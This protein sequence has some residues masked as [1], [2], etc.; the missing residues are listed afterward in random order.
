MA[1][2]QET[3]NSQNGIDVFACDPKGLRLDSLGMMLVI[4]W[5]G[6]LLWTPCMVPPSFV[7]SSDDF[8]IHLYR[9]TFLAAFF[10]VYLVASLRPRFAFTV[11][12]H[13][14]VVVAATIV[15]PLVPAVC[16]Y[17]PLS[18][19]CNAIS[20]LPFV[21]WA[22]EGVSAS[23]FMLVWCYGMQTKDGRTNGVTNVVASCFFAGTIYLLLA[24]LQREAAVAL[25]MVLPVIA[26]LVWFYLR[27]EAINADSDVES[28]TSGLST[29]MGNGSS[30][31]VFSYGLAMGAIGGIATQFDN[32]TYFFLT[33]GVSSIASGVVFVWLS[34][35][36]ITLGRR[37]LM[38]C[39]PLISLSFFLLS[40]FVEAIEVAVVFLIVFLV[41]TFNSFN[42]AYIGEESVDSSFG[43]EYNLFL[44]EKR[45]WDALGSLVG[46][47]G[48]T[49]VVYFWHTDIAG[50]LYFALSLAVT[51]AMALAFIKTYETG[52]FVEAADAVE[53]A[54]REESNS[55]NW[56]DA[57]AIISSKYG[58]SPRESEIFVYLSKGR[59]RGFIAQ[60]MFLS[61]NTV[62]S[63]TYNIYNK[64]GI[65]KQQQL[66]S[67][68]EE[69]VLNES[70][71]Q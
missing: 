20:I 4:S 28:E 16:L 46:W 30:V 25:V 45:I 67:E 59:N 71:A 53:E 10:L 34:K 66:I 32:A 31:F 17:Q 19:L 43:A 42:T 62:R 44:S 22:L 56:E 52:D 40:F 35:V 27:D 14:V 37:A 38:L 23:V 49:V 41:Q 57:C 63:H 15:S 51:A 60:E 11:K 7:S 18:E 5:F 50:H 69:Q 70:Q 13:P 6:A 65:H 2:C 1:E 21:I 58:L 48:S 29:L 24:F 36:G 39:L 26:L 33:F 68:V 3:G 8:I 64:M 9:L 12:T 55:A 47:A 61:P 54:K